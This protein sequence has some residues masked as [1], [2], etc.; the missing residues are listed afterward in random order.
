MHYCNIF[1]GI[2]N[3]FLSNAYKYVINILLLCALHVY[4]NSIM[5]IITFTHYKSIHHNLCY[6][7]TVYSLQY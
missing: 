7:L 4:N 3:T 5:A 1:L 6:K 2:D